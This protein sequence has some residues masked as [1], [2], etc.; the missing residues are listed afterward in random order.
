[1]K[2]SRNKFRFYSIN[3][4]LGEPALVSL[5]HEHCIPVFHASSAFRGKGKKSTWQAWYEEV[6]ET[7][8]FSAGHSFE[9]LR[10]DSIHFCRIERFI[11]PVSPLSFVNEAREDLFCQKNHAMDQQ[12]M[13]YLSTFNVQ[14]SRLEYGQHALK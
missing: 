13:L 9:H 2:I 11:K 10:Y 7:S 4:I 8:V 14:F 5:K 12:E 3:H 6:T 1:M